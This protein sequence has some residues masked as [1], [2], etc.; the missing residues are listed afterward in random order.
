MT[1]KRNRIKQ[2]TTLEERL[3]RFTIDLRQQAQTLDPGTEEAMTLRK[4]IRQGESAL[5]LNASLTGGK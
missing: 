3:S 5:R 4:R 2:T 1:K